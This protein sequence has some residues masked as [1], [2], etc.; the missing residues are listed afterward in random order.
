MILGGFIGY[1][2]GKTIRPWYTPL[3]N[4]VSYGPRIE[5]CHSNR[6]S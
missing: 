3:A 5:K 2:V 4:A 1:S 6:F